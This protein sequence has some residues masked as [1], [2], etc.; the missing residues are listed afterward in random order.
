[1]LYPFVAAGAVIS[2]LICMFCG[3]SYW[4]EVPLLAG[5]TVALIALY[6]IV[7]F[8][9]SLFISKKKP[10]KSCKRYYRFLLNFTIS[11]ILK[12]ARVRIKVSGEERLPKDGG[13]LIVG[14]H[15]SNF[16]PMVTIAVLKK[17]NISYITKPE[18]LKIPIAGSFIYKCCFLPIDR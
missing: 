7:L 3:I 9:H 10:Q 18:N 17:Y 2:L 15:V 6:F 13:F 14:N 8:V 16:D 5:C 12:L 1:M 4:W 11:L